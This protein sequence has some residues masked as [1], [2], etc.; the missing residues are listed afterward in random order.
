MTNSKRKRSSNFVRI[1][2]KEEMGPNFTTNFK[3]GILDK[4]KYDIYNSNNRFIDLHNSL[5]EF[6]VKALSH[7]YISRFQLI[8]SLLL[9][10]N[11]V[12]ELL[13]FHQIRNLKIDKKNVQSFSKVEDGLKK[14]L[15]QKE[16]PK[17]IEI[18]NSI[19]KH[20]RALRNQ[21]AH[22]PYGGLFFSADHESFESFV[23]KLKGIKT[24]QSKHVMI[25]GK[26]GV[27]LP[28]QIE[29]YIYIQEFYE[30]SILFLSMI[31]EYFFPTIEDK[32]YEFE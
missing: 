31:L 3:F 17:E 12:N 25:D 21:F 13:Y 7:S 19:I 26:A 4:Y 22:Y 27:Y 23:L 14:Y 5:G 29:S 1:M 6:Q 16:M 18:K 9:F 8:E 30:L 24:F 11:A 28:Y 2:P 20:Y 15:I 32:L 10:D